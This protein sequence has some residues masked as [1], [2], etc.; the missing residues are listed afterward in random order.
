MEKIQDFFKHVGERLS[1]PFLFSFLISWLI[2]N[3]KVTIGLLFYS[4]PELKADGYS[5]YLDLIAKSVTWCIGLVYPLIGAGLYTFAFPYLKRFIALLYIRI[6]QGQEKSTIKILKGNVISTDKYLRLRESY[7]E[8]QERLSR[9]I[10]EE[11]DFFRER[12]DLNKQLSILDSDLTK[13]K[14]TIRDLEEELSVLKLK[15]KTDV[16]FLEGGWFGMVIFKNT[17]EQD[18]IGIHFSLKGNFVEIKFRSSKAV[19]I[20]L[21]S[22]LRMGDKMYVE[23]SELDNKITDLIDQYII[24]TIVREV[25]IVGFGKYG[26][27]Y[28]LEKS[29]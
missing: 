27:H 25:R 21:N 15:T 18:A 20:T 24:F 4:I 13:A 29:S 3:Y 17:N 1:N 14:L 26:T 12:N 23:F 7:K 6:N 11:S 8:S 9:V 16:E 22:V 2:S 10:E 19:K 28:D 5:S